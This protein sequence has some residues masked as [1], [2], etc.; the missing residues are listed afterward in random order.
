MNL[1]VNFGVNL[2]WG[3]FKVGVNLKW[4]YGEIVENM[5]NYRLFETVIFGPIK[6]GSEYLLGAGTFSF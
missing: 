5:E 3:E 2:R 4:G 6:T 1:R